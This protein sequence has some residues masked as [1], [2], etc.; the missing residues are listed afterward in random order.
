MKTLRIL[1]V[2]ALWAA[3][4][5]PA[6]AEK[7]S[8]GEISSY[9][10]SL[11]TAEG[12]FTQVN[13]DGS[14]STGRILLKRPGKVRFEYDPPEAALVV[15]DGATVGIIDPRSNER[16]GYPLHRTPLKIILERNVDLTRARM[17]TGHASDGTATTV[18]AQDPDNP[19]YGSIDLVFTADPVELRQ[20]I[21]N[22][23]NGGRTTVILGDL[24][25]GVRLSDEN[26][27]IPGRD[28]TRIDR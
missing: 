27:V 22:D 14:I 19:D 6:A 17:V 25:T 18:R 28:R 24:A 23:A 11:R 10:N 12:Q 4:T 26:F 3:M 16:Q 21:I 8:L 20:W 2:P 9:L 5:L 15:A 1:M 13:E 7:L